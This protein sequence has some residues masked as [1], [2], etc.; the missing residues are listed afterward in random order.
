MSE[1]R[2]PAEPDRAP[3]PDGETVAL[4]PPGPARAQAQ[5]EAAERGALERAETA[6]VP[7]G[8]PAPE[9]ARA[10]EAA[11]EGGGREALA[12]AETAVLA[13]AAEAGGSPPARGRQG[14][15]PGDRFG[16]YEVVGELGRGGMGVVYRAVDRDLGREVALKVLPDELARRP[17]EAARFRR[18]A[19]LASKLRHPRIV[20]VY[21]F[22]E[23]EGRLYY[24]MPIVEGHSLREAV[25]AG[26]LEPEA[27][28]RLLAEVARAIDAA[29]QQ[30]VVH[31]DLKPANVVLDSEGGPLVLDFGLA[32]D[33]GHGP[34][35]TRTGEIL[36]TPCYM[37]PE[38][39][40]GEV[41]EADHRVDVYSLG[42]ILYELLTGKVPYDGQSVHEVV[43][44][45]LVS[46]PLPPRRL[47]PQIPY[48]LETVV[49]KAMARE[50]F[51]RYQTAG[52]LADDLER[53]LEREPVVARRPGLPARAVR[54]VRSHRSATVLALLLLVTIAGF[55]L[56]YRRGAA[57]LA[58]VQRSDQALEL[59]KSARGLEG[60]DDEAAARAHLEAHLLAQGAFADEPGSGRTLK[61]LL[62]VLRARAR[63]AEGRRDWTL[64]EELRGR[65]YRLSGQE[66][67]REAWRR[68]RGLAEV[69]V[70][71]LGEGESLDFVRWDRARG[72]PDPSRRA[73]ATAREPEVELPAGS[74]LARLRTR[75]TG[76]SHPHQ[77][78]DERGPFHAA[79]LAAPRFLVVLGRGQ[80]Q[81]LR[82][83]DPGPA[84]A[85]MAFVPA[86]ELVVTPPPG[87][88]GGPRV[89]R[90][91]PVW[92]DRAEVT[93][94]AYREFLAHVEAEGHAACGAGD[95][96]AG[97]DHWPLGLS[98]RPGGPT[99]EARP[100]TGVSWHDAAAY[101]RWAG[102]RLPSRAEWLLAAGAAD[103]RRYPWG[104]AW[105]EG[106][107]NLRRDDLAP[108]LAY[109]RDVS[110][111]G[112][113]ALCGNADEWCAD[114]HPGPGG[115]E[116]EWRVIVG[117]GAPEAAERVGLAEA[118]Y[119]RA[120]E[121]FQDT[122]FRCAQDAPAAGSPLPLGVAA[123]TTPPRPAPR[124]GPPI[125]LRV[126]AWPGYA[127]PELAARFAARYLERTGVAVV[128]SQVVT[129]TTNDEYLELLRAGAVDLV[130]PSC[131]MA[132]AIVR[133]GLVQ[134][135]ELAREA[136]LLPE[137]RS[138]PFLHHQGRTYG[139]C[140]TNG[141][142]WLVSL[143]PAVEATSWRAL[144]DPALRGRIA[145]WDDAVWAITVAALDLGLRPAFDLSDEELA[146]VEDRLVALLK[147]DCRLWSYPED[148]ER[149]AE[150]G[151]ALVDDWGIVAWRL[152]Q[153]GWTLRRTLPEG[154]SALWIDS[155]M[156][157][158]GCTGPRLEAARAWVDYAV[159]PENQ[160]A[161]LRRTAY[162]PV[163][164]ETVRL[165]DKSTARARLRTIQQRRAVGLDRWREVPRRER[166]L[167]VWASAKRRAAEE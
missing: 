25:E 160:A 151:L 45:I 77:R 17:R 42:A 27:A 94:A 26:P 32:K 84:P 154:G 127:A 155:W 21:A 54:W 110:P 6:V 33:L 159:S 167:E 72:E 139:V 62:E 113:V 79:D 52:A 138:P 134:P 53:F 163:N 146:R 142:M 152:Q 1:P 103:G 24:T 73:Q 136:E 56:F 74:Y 135:L 10:A 7:S 3:S 78:P 57:R 67:D 132:P 46:E 91:G 44:K 161:L 49:L 162:D 34:D 150:Q 98:R 147:N 30:R 104:D 50:P 119:A 140:Y 59:A 76:G 71:G 58:A 22:G 109:A 128:V 141:P 148:A 9:P 156:I 133:A 97:R 63:F 14:L 105:E 102:K 121:R 5:A 35:L 83:A 165:L 4:P 66:T 61:A 8:S 29:H 41:G 124:P 99:V 2:P 69:T 51:L 149:L 118:T 36:G 145:L 40:R 130:A 122:G 39:A 82:V 81:T 11:A 93:V 100:V 38:Q 164:A 166:Y 48:D 16:R 114:R 123:P 88:G 86:A 65:C 23:E 131:D 116:Q 20:G 43:R 112:A 87:E 157:A 85:G 95:G 143:D 106:R 15:A 125:V 47:R 144:W 60:R 101:A 75:R 129:V 111:Y 108:A 18:E 115:A 37:S 68:A 28:A 92:I 80:Q 158:K 107:A 126:A 117:G 13:S 96:C 70:A 31:R 120:D 55:A 90:A 89:E 64:A 19:A 12:Q 137:F 153:R